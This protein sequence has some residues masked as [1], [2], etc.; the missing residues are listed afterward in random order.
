MGEELRPGQRVV[1][2]S[3]GNTGVVI[4]LC[5]EGCCAQV[6]P[7]LPWSRPFECPTWKLAPIADAP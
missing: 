4:A 6:E 2:T 1:H 7:D 3:S 5:D